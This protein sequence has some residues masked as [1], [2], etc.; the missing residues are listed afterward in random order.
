MRLPLCVT[1]EW[2]ALSGSSAKPILVPVEALYCNDNDNTKS[3]EAFQQPP[4]PGPNHLP[5]R[6]LDLLGFFV[7]FCFCF[8]SSGYSEVAIVV[9]LEE[10]NRT[11]SERHRSLLRCLGW[12]QS[13]QIGSNP[14]QPLS[15]KVGL[16]FRQHVEYRHCV[17]ANTV[18][19]IDS[20]SMRA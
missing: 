11:Y 9:T 6:V 16:G 4:C 7:G 12:H 19:S 2:I 3:C 10:P 13:F 15:T 17:V 14:A 18:V 20:M 5:A 8:C 1:P